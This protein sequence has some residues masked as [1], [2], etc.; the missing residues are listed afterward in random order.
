L[1]AVTDVPSRL[2][3][4]GSATYLATFRA[5]VGKYPHRQP[6]EMLADLVASTPGQE[7]K[8]FAAAKDAKLYDAAIKLAGRSPCDPRTLTR[9]ARDSAETEPG[10]A[11]EAGLLALRWLVQGYGY[12]ITAAVVW[13][14]YTQTMQAAERMGCGDAARERIR[15]L[16]AAEA[17]GDRF[18]SKILGGE[19]RGGVSEY[20][21]YEFIAL[22]RPLT[23]TV[24]VTA[25]RPYFPGDAGAG[26]LTTS[27]KHVILDLVSE[28]D[29]PE[30]DWFEA[31]HLAASLAPV[32]AGLLGGDLR[33][34]YLAWL[35][36][37]RAGEVEPGGLEKPL[38]RGI[39][40]SPPPLA[41]LAEFLRID[42]D[43]L[44][45]VAE[46][47]TN[48]GRTRAGFGSGSGACLPVSGTDGCCGPRTTRASPWARSCSAR[49]TARIRR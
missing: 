34:A 14:A 38:P 22:D 36:A 1:I 26:A 48:E 41:A 15:Q 21:A 47:A 3:G 28:V 37:V 20:Q 16:V 31:G 42:Q 10:F 11:V 40:Q 43:L 19:V 6:A 9:A 13:A 39:G 7:G 24:D 44:A 4:T 27:G 5:V 45:A 35:L 2:A 12:E 46:A 49:F 29:E 18:V 17:V 8:W 23:T 33:A 30:D 32:R 25:L